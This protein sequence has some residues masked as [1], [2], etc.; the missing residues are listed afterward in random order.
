[1]EIN[2]KIDLGSMTKAEITDY[3]KSIGEAKFRAE[4]VYGWLCRGVPLSEMT[5]LSLALRSRLAETCLDTVPRVEKKLVSAFDLFN[6][7]Y[8]LNI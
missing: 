2:G 6:R 7:L 5:N 8:A 1:M 3:F 4:Q